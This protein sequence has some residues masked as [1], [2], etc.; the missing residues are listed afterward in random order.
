MPNQGTTATVPES[1]LVSSQRLKSHFLWGISL[2]CLQMG[3]KDLVCL[4]KGWLLHRL[5][6]PCVLP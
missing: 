6:A 5:G 1:S 4:A 3:G 2:L